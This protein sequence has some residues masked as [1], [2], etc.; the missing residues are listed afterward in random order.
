MKNHVNFFDLGED[1]LYLV[2]A[3]LQADSPSSILDLAKACKRCNALATPFLYHSIQ[4]DEHSRTRQLTSRLVDKNDVIY[5]HVHE[6]TVSN[7][8]NKEL[9]IDEAQLLHVISN[10]KRLQIFR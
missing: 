6:I 10:V 8:K 2:T 9:Q 1:I 4:F 3:Q 7:S 5:H